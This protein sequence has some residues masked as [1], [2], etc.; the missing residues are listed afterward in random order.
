MFKPKTVFV[1]GAAA[2]QN[3]GFPLGA[4]FKTQIA[5]FLNYKTNEWGEGSFSNELYRFFQAFRE[6]HEPTLI[7]A[8][9]ITN[10][11]GYASSIDHFLEMRK[12]D[13]H[14]TACAKATIAHLILKKER[15][16]TKLHAQN[17]NK[18]LASGTE[19]DNTWQQK[20]AEICFERCEENDLPDALSRVSFISFNYDRSIE[21]FIRV[22]IAALYSLPFSEA[23]QIASEYFTVLHPY[24]SLG[25]LH[26]ANPTEII[27][28][29]AERP[30]DPRLLASNLHTFTEQLKE[31]GDLA[32]IKKLVQN[33]ETII[34]LGFG[35]HKQN[36]DIL[37]PNE[38]YKNKRVIGTAKGM[39]EQAK[40]ITSSNLR[41]VLKY[42]KSP[43][44]MNF[45]N[46]DLYDLDCTQLMSEH[47]LSLIDIPT[48]S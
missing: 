13:P 22:A 21:Q 36:V 14:I 28:F 16:A 3:F 37:L 40:N 15:N 1:I 24:G 12:S 29:G 17:P 20:F 47:Q 11:L 39:S 32:E 5:D 8:K 48:T 34:F 31:D 45:P 9:K 19:F 41:R 30:L 2:S 33:A 25:K 46:I 23:D 38:N 44:S 42:G 26:S 35:Y 7:A 27:Q 10:G 43:K 4:K 6:S 18:P